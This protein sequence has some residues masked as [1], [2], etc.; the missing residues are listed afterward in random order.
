MA[1]STKLKSGLLSH[2]LVFAFGAVFFTVQSGAP[3][4]WMLWWGLGLALHL[5]STLAKLKTLKGE[6]GA[7][8]VAQEAAREEGLIDQVQEAL[9]ELEMAWGDQEA[10]SAYAPDFSRLSETADTLHERHQALRELCGRADGLQQQV[11][12][13][14]QRIAASPSEAEANSLERELDALLDRVESQEAAQAVVRQLESELRTLLHRAE[15][16]RLDV[17]HR[18]VDVPELDTR[19]KEI[20]SRLDAAAEV[21][22]HLARARR[23]ARARTRG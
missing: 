6:A 11:Q 20:R 2:S 3:P 15:A 13:L 1:S 17:M 21:D 23:A 19:A 22:E 12:G 16:L 14:R 4:S 9:S 8:A 10:L 18:S 5:V 7:E